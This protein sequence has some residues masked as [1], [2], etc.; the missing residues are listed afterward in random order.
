[1]TGGALVASDVRAACGCA[2]MENMVP[3]PTRGRE[4]AAG[5]G[6]SVSLSGS[7]RTPCAGRI[8]SGRRT[9]GVC[10]NGLI[11]T[12]WSLLRYSATAECGLGI[13]RVY[14][15]VPPTGAKRSAYRRDPEDAPRK[16]EP[17]C[18]IRPGG[19][20]AGAR[21]PPPST[22]APCASVPRLQPVAS[23]TRLLQLVFDGEC[24]V[25]GWARRHACRPSHP[26]PAARGASFSCAF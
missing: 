5:A 20:A 12:T 25:A 22:G 23:R 18:Q 11:E 6:V 4:S 17:T 7:R 1:M 3:H 9:D 8:C 13:L 19:G 21:R 15:A 16:S 24:A 10:E 14:C 26:P 2:S